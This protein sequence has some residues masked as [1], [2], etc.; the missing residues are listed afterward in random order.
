MVTSYK[1]DFLFRFGALGRNGGGRPPVITTVALDDADEGVAYSFQLAA[2]GVVTAWSI[3]SGA[4]QAGLSLNASTGEISGTPSASGTVNITVRAAGPSGY[5]EAELTLTSNAS[6]DPYSYTTMNLNAGFRA[7][8]VTITDTD[9]IDKVDNTGDGDLSLY[10]AT[11]ARPVWDSDGGNGKPCAVFD[12]SDDWLRLRNGAASADSTLDAIINNNAGWILN[13]FKV[14]AADVATDSGS[15]QSNDPVFIDHGAYVLM[16]LRDTAGS[17]TIYSSNW[18]GG[19]D[20]CTAS[21]TFD[22]VSV[23]AWNHSGG[24]LYLM[25]VSG[26]LDSLTSGNTSSLIQL[27]RWFGSSAGNFL[28]GQLY[29]TMADD[30][31]PVDEADILTGMGAYY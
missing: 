14:S 12:G 25:G 22:A 16:T 28:A 30:V 18:D 8:D 2:T 5:D 26:E 11:T 31:V 13:V 4:L 20:N 21:L 10:S 1:N 9:K 7:G 29:H 24:T 15:P 19:Y 17:G 6:F 27:P 3:T 23:Y